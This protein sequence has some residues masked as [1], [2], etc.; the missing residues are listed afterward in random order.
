VPLT[1]KKQ[2]KTRQDFENIRQVLCGTVIRD[3]AKAARKVAEDCSMFFTRS[4]KVKASLP[5]YAWSLVLNGSNDLCPGEWVLFM[6][7]FTTFLW[8]LRRKRGL[9]GRR[10]PRRQSQLGAKSKME[11]ASG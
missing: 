2:K 9:S 11:Q 7:F 3:V 1:K 5:I 8:D 4:P 6:S 10:P